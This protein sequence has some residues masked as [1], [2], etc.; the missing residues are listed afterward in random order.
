MLYFI[1]YY[2]HYRK[3]PEWE[4]PRSSPVAELMRARRELALAEKELQEKCME[5]KIQRKNMDQLWEE[6]RSNEQSLR[7]SFIKFNKLVKENH[8]KR[9]R[10]ENK[11]KE[12]RERQESRME[13]VRKITSFINFHI[14]KKSIIKIHF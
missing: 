4:I 3:Y 14:Q 7:Q 10:A 1:Y 13:E 8:E 6:L 9:E 5:Q 12:E 11:I 2:N